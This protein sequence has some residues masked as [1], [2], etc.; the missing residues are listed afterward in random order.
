MMMRLVL[1]E[2]KASWYSQYEEEEEAPTQVRTP[3]PPSRLETVPMTE[4]DDEDDER[5]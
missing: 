5:Q 3:L 4:N 1:E 2:R